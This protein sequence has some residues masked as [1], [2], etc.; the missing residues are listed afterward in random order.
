MTSRF[1]L[2]FIPVLLISL[3][4]ANLIAPFLPF[5]FPRIFN[6]CL[7]VFAFPTAIFFQKKIRKKPF[8]EIGLSDGGYAIREIARGVFLS[9]VSL[10][11]VTLVSMAFGFSTVEFHPPPHMRKIFNY[12]LASVLTAFFE[13]FFF[14]GL[15]FKVLS[16]DY[17]VPLSLG[18]SSGIYSFAHFVRPFFTQGADFSLFYTEIVGLFLF[19]LLLSYAFYRTG[20]LYFPMGL[21]GGFVLLLKLD[22]ILINRLTREPAWVFGKERLVGG[23]V[24]WVM[25]LTLFPAIRRLT[26]SR[27]R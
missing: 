16:D 9:F 25:F 2:F 19:G 6:R 17:S 22:G 7:L 15:L 21:H 24:T 20:S 12:V 13:E 27:N 11:A 18:I 23:V 14:R 5:S 26:R 10:L 3:S 4:A 8:S 1:F